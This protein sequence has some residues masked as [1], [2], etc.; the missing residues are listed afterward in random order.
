LSAK[1][2]QDNNSM[3]LGLHHD[4]RFG[5]CPATVSALTLDYI[6]DDYKDADAGRRITV[7][8]LLPSG[9]D[10]STLHISLTPCNRVCVMKFLMSHRLL[11]SKKAYYSHVGT[12][13][14]GIKG[15]ENR[16]L[17]NHC[18]VVACNATVAMIKKRDNS[19]KVVWKV[20]RIPL[21]TMVQTTLVTKQRDDIF[22]GIK[23]VKYSDGKIH[24]I[25]HYLEDAGDS[26]VP[27]TSDQHYTVE[28]AMSVTPSQQPAWRGI[29]TTI[30]H[31]N[32][33][34]DID[35]NTIITTYS[36][37]KQ[38]QATTTTSTHR[39]R[40]TCGHS[41]ISH[42]Q[43]LLP[44]HQEVRDDTADS[45]SDYGSDSDN[46]EDEDNHEIG[47]IT[48]LEC[49]ACAADMGQVAAAISKVYSTPV[50]ELTP[51]CPDE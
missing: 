22:Y 27:E 3:A 38:K 9:I 41:V 1:K 39:G 31:G 15:H 26:Y 6:V 28:D 2:Q 23:F 21:P 45:D 11:N 47:S 18:T 37:T 49:L 4:I 10:V 16:L 30:H 48:F 42:A 13:Q 25:I 43:E 7:Q 51:K 36:A 14:N 29:P 17:K 33:P 32:T 19:K 8:A 46:E 34:M 5:S 35:E 40:T 24:V 50:A 44:G 12:N 20:A